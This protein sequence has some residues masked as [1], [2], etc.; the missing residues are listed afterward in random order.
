MWSTPSTQ[1]LIDY[2][3]ARTSPVR[4]AVPSVIVTMNEVDGSYP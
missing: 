2:T 4:P 3:D 1:V